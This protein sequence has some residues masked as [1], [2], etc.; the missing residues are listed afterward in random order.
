MEEGRD[1]P[2]YPLHQVYQEVADLFIKFQNST[3]VDFEEFLYDMQTNTI[4]ICGNCQRF[5]KEKY[6]EAQ[7][8][9]GKQ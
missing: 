2:K 8:G 6:T 5:V 9:C 4:Q 1:I 3:Y 7:C